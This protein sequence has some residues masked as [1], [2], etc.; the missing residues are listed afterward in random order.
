MMLLLSYFKNR[1]SHLSVSFQWIQSLW[2]IHCCEIVSLTISPRGILRVI[3]LDVLLCIEQ[4]QHKENK[5]AILRENP[6]AEIPATP[7]R[8]K[9]SLKNKPSYL[10]VSYFT[11]DYLLISLYRSFLIGQQEHLEGGWLL[12]GI[13]V[14]ILRYRWS[15]FNGCISAMIHITQNPALIII[16]LLSLFV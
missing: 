5:L 10:K 2:P 4:V 1:G 12:N 6:Y 14:P 3:I 15:F 13:L 8:P 16:G 9:V 7:N 11:Y